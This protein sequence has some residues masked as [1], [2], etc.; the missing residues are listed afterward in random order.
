MQEILN[1]EF[2]D[3]HS[4]SQLIKVKKIRVN[5]EVPKEHIH[6]TPLPCLRVQCKR[7]DRESIRAQSSR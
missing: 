6:C 3:D 2:C 7:E 5:S 4:D 1:A